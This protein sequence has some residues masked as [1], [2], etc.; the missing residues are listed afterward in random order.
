MNTAPIL[1]LHDVHAY[2]GQSHVLQGISSGIRPA[3]VT[4]ILGRNGVGKT[5]TLKSI[6]GLIAHTGRIEFDGQ[7]ISGLETHEIVRLASATSPRTARSS[8]A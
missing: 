2:I 3:Q 7:P 8:T 4:V 6:L 5:S 1:S